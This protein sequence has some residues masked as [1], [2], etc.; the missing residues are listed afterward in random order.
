[1]LL[2]HIGGKP[3]V[4]F[5]EGIVTVLVFTAYIP[6]GSNVTESMVFAASAMG[7]NIWWIHDSSE[8]GLTL[9]M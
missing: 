8:I 2:Y 6:T 4:L 5:S 9:P 3:L 1:M 7:T